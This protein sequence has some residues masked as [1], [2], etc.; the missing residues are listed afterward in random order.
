MPKT[1]HTSAPSR[2]VGLEMAS[3]NRAMLGRRER[4]YWRS[5]GATEDNAARRFAAGRT[6][7]ALRE[8]A[9]V[10]I[11]PH[12]GG[13]GALIEARRLGQ[14]DSGVSDGDQVAPDRSQLAQRQRA[15]EAAELLD[16][17]APGRDHDAAVP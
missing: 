1:P 17:R 4:Q 15:G 10:R 3:E 8:G 7:H 13:D 9:L 14:V 5:I 12:R 11:L 16:V 2:D 6:V